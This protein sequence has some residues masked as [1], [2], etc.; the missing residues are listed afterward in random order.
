MK[1]TRRAAFCLG[2]T[3]FL[4]MALTG[5]AHPAILQEKQEKA[6][7]PIDTLP[8][9]AGWETVAEA[10]L[11][12]QGKAHLPLEKIADVLAKRETHTF[13]IPFTMTG[14]L[15]GIPVPKMTVLQCTVDRVR[16]G[17]DLQKLR[18]L[19]EQQK[20]QPLSVIAFLYPTNR[21][22]GEVYLVDN[23]TQALVPETLENLKAIRQE[24]VQQE[25]INANFNRLAVARPDSHQQEVSCLL[26]D[27][28]NP[29]K[30]RKAF[31]KLRS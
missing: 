16:E 17:S 12:V 6:L 23:L 9:Y 24:I 28:C 1:T 3:T 7:P 18:E 31:G 29:Q 27:L 15:K 21:E 13:A 14:V 8:A 19:Q 4:D 20:N 2:I 25:R 30:Q 5:Q 10:P 22:Q 26:T 11:I